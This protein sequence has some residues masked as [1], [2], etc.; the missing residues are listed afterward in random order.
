MRR[1]ER[2]THHHNLGSVLSEWPKKHQKD[3]LTRSRHLEIMITSNSSAPAAAR[4]RWAGLRRWVDYQPTQKLA[5]SSGLPF[6]TRESSFPSGAK[7]IGICHYKA[8][9]TRGNASALC[10]SK[11]KS[12]PA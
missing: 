5:A 6:L 12:G 2:P 11:E 4:R 9:A 1:I 3:R 7:V 8:Q 10:A